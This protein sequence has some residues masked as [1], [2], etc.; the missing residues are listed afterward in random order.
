MRILS[1]LFPQTISETSSAFVENRFQEKPLHFY[2]ALSPANCVCPPRKHVAF[3]Y[4]S[5]ASWG[6]TSLPVEGNPIMTAPP[7]Q[8]EMRPIKSATLHACLCLK[9]LGAVGSKHCEQ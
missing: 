1:F 6:T 3:H 2:L 4:V 5:F 9:F 7:Q 8:M